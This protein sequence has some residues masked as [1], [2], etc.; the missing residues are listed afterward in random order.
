MTDDLELI[1]YVYQNAEMGVTT[2]NELLK[3]YS[4]CHFL[5]STHILEYAKAFELDPFCCFYYM[6][7]EIKDDNFVCP[8]RLQKG[9]SEARVGYWV[10]R[11]LLNM[12]ELKK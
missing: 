8:H 11:K 2:L 1:E 9:I 10:V 3:E 4:N 5:I 12:A 7:A 6:E